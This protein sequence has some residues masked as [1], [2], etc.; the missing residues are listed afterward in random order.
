MADLI[1]SLIPSKVCTKC[2]QSKPISC[3]HSK[4]AGKLGVHSICKP[5]RSSQAQ[6]WND[7]NPEKVRSIQAEAKRRTRLTEAGR[8]KLVAINQK[9]IENNRETVRA[10]YRERRASDPLFAIKTRY[11]GLLTKAVNRGGFTKRSKSMQI[12]GCDWDALKVHIERQFTNGMSWARIGEIH[13]DHI[14]PMVTAKNEDDVIRLSNY[15]NL[16]PMWARENLQK[17]GKSI[18]LL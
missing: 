15:M 1:L 8:N 7:R 3:Y 2:S 4:P 9:Y 17:S 11:R 12:L 16:R 6:G 10:Y 18:Y 14:I 13:I 5:C